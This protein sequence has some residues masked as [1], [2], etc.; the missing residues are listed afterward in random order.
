MSTLDQMRDGFHHTVDYLAEGWHTL[1][2]HATHALT[3]FTPQQKAGELE[4]VEDQLMKKSAGWGFL[5]AEV[6][7]EDDKVLV[8]LEIPGM[9]HDS[10][11][12]HVV[13]DVLVVRGEKQVE[14]EENTGRYYLLERAYGAFERAVQLPAEV[15][16]DK[17]EAKYKRGVLYLTFPKTQHRT[18]RRIAVTSE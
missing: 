3:R 14:R 6:K 17:A 2:Q 18:Y 13:D 4:T 5:A 16:E 7:E 1:R 8:R 15:D 10:F 11:E 9:D 12:I